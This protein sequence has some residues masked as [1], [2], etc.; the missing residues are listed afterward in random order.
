[1]PNPVES[2]IGTDASAPEAQRLLRDGPQPLHDQIAEWIR[3]RI[4]SAVWPANYKLPPEPAIAS[5]FEVSRGTVRRALQTLIDEG[6]LVQVQGKGTFVTLGTFDSPIAQDLLSLA[7]ALQLRGLEFQT[8]VLAAE[9]VQPSERTDELLGLP[10]AT[11]LFRLERLRTVADTP[12]ALSVNYVRLDLCP[13]IEKHDFSVRTLFDVIEHDYELSIASGGRNFNAQAADGATA[14]ALEV[15][16]GTP[17]LYLEQVTYSEDGAPIEYSDVWIRGDRLR[18][19]T[20]LTRHKP[21]TYAR[22]RSQ[23]TSGHS[24]RL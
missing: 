2:P 13:G 3:T 23:Q 6:L 9:I 11:P 10:A 19:T 21:F 15:S 5:T 17:L 16:E 12:V 8:Q 1:M 4:L 20:F 24:A 14:A 7:E 18:L 22:T